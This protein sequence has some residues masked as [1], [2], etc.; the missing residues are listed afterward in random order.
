MS[1]NNICFILFFILLENILNFTNSVVCIVVVDD[2]VQYMP[3]GDAISSLSFQSAF[4]LVSHSY[5]ALD[6]I[7]HIIIS[8]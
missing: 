6:G 7:Y 8:L 4:Q 3:G 5:L 2:W 1:L